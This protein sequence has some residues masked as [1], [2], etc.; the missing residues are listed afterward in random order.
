MIDLDNI[1]ISATE[2][3]EF[4]AELGMT[5]A[6]ELFIKSLNCQANDDGT[7]SY[8]LVNDEFIIQ[9]SFSFAKKLATKMFAVV[10]EKTEA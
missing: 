10:S 2:E 4:I 6:N 5:V 7:T 1:E 8:T 3:E 9:Q